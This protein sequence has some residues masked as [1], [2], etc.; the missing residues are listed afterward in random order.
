MNIRQ[1]KKSEWSV[2]ADI[3]IE[4]W[5]DAY[6]NVLPDQYLKCHAASDIRT[7]WSKKCVK[8]DDLILIAEDG[9]IIGFI[10]IWCR[11]DAFIDNL[12]VKPIHRSKKIGR[13]LMQAAA[14]ELILNGKN[15]AYLWV[16]VSNQAAIRFYEGLGGER[17][18]TARKN[19]F[20]H[21]VPS[22]KMVWNDI[23]VMTRL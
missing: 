8:A 19:I 23:S 17:K 21:L 9:D 18:E 12:H 10:A 20:G 2:I 16:F 7:F 14:R 22:I 13:A 4:S 15:S 6:R 11:P 3:H 1:A 5:Q